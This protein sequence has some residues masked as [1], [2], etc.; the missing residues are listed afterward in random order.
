MLLFPPGSNGI[1]CHLR[2]NSPPLKVFDENGTGESFLDVV[3]SRCVATAVTR[4]KAQV[5]QMLGLVTQASSGLPAVNCSHLCKVPGMVHH[6][7]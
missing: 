6:Q 3:E 7:V 1:A 2:M 4:C 5:A